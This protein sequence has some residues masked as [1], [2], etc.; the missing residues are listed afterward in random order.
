MSAQSRKHRGYA[1][2]RMCAEYWRT[3]GFPYVTDTGAGR[4]GADLINTPGVSVEIKA[5]TGFEPKAWIKQAVTSAGDDL[6]VAV[7]RPNGSGET[8]IGEWPVI[9]RHS[10]FLDLLER[11][12]YTHP[13]SKPTEREDNGVSGST[14]V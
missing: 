11:A 2:Q 3:R 13:I 12:G 8:T 10:D 4:Q 9:L 1:T 14:A 7:L 6:P 5:R